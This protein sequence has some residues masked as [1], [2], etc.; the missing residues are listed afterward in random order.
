MSDQFEALRIELRHRQRM[1][2]MFRAAD[3]VAKAAIGTVVVM[4]LI[5]SVFLSGGV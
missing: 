2:A 3:T 1:E 4:V 5:Y